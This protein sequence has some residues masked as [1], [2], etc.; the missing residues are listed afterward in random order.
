M[1]IMIRFGKDSS[2]SMETIK[3]FT[4][5][6]VI[7]FGPG[8]DH[9]SFYLISSPSGVFPRPMDDF[10]EAAKDHLLLGIDG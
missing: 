1:R 5:L 7:H 6:V 2:L 3:E 4:V 8:S 10:G 9:F